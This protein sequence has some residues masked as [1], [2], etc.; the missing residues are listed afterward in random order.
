MW[1]ISLLAEEVGCRAKKDSAARGWSL[2][3]D[4]HCYMFAEASAAA[5][6]RVGQNSS[7]VAKILHNLQGSHLHTL[8][9]CVKFIGQVHCSRN[10]RDHN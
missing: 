4:M 2:L 7:V 8:R 6:C 1:G 9:Y 10:Q 5:G 3:T